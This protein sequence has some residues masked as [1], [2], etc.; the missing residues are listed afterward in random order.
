MEANP[1]TAGKELEEINTQYWV[2]TFLVGPEAWANFRR[3]GFP[4]LTPNPYPGKDLKTEPFIRRL[5][6][7]DAELNV[8]KTNVQAA[9]A[10]Q[11]ADIMDTRIWWDKK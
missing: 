8:N 11:G 6:Y 4:N 10:R 5:T 3:S 1:L 9:I 2:A 7:T